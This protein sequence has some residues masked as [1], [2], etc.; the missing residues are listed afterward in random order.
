[1]VTSLRPGRSTGEQ[2]LFQ[3]GLGQYGSLVTSSELPQPATQRVPLLLITALKFATNGLLRLP[4]PFIGD[5]A[6]G[7]NTTTASVGSFLSVGE[8]SGLLGATA[9]RDMDRGRHRRWLMTGFGMCGVGGGI[10]AGLR[11]SAGLLIGFCLISIGVNLA[12]TAGHSFIGSVTAFAKRARS[13]GIFETSWA[14]S[15][16]L[17]GYVAGRM[18]DAFGWWVPF[19]VFGAALLFATPVLWFKMSAITVNRFAESD[20]LVG[21]GDGPF[22]FSVVARVVGLS[23]V[24]TFAQVLLFSSMGPFLENRHSFDTKGI[25]ALIFGLGCLELVGSGATATLTDRFGKRNAILLGIVVMSVGVLILLLLGGTSRIAATV[26]ILMFFLGFEFSY[27][28]LLAVVSEV[29]GARRGAVLSFDHAAVTV[30]RAAGA[31]VGPRLV[32]VRA[33]NFRLVHTAVI[34]LTVVCGLIVLSMH[35]DKVRQETG[36]DPASDSTTNPVSVNAR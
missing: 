16:L 6:R 18:I 29:G 20:A 24:V 4:Y 3:L 26:A 19:A 32:G 5:L 23:M 7:L 8:L 2:R 13:I 17:G 12:T 35:Q 21:T 11:S 28:S 36:A 22:V 10:I 27:V 31:F 15:L 30:T 14:L 1:M 33:E 25:G 34:V 9:G